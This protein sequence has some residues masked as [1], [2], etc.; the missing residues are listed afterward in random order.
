MS[1]SEIVA[2]LNLTIGKSRVQN[3]LAADRNIKYKKPSKKNHNLPMRIK[4]LMDSVITGIIC[5]KIIPLE[6]AV[7]FDS[8]SVMILG[9]FVYHGKLKVCFITMKMDSKKYI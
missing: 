6:W 9:G 7:N 2:T 1:A 5:A 4:Y 3:I 8:G